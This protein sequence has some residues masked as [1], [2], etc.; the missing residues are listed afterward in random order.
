MMSTEPQWFV[1]QGDQQLGPYTGAQLV[2]FATQGNILRETPVWTEGME[3]WLPAEQI[4]GV[5][6]PAAAVEAAPG[7]ATQAAPGMATQPAPGMAPALDPSAPYPSP[8]TGNGLF[9]LWAGMFLGGIAMIIVGFLLVGVLARNSAVK[10]GTTGGMSITIEETVVGDGTPDETL[11]ELAAAEPDVS[12]GEVAGVL[13]A[14]LLGM[15]GYLLV[16]LSFIPFYMTLYRAW[17]CLVPGGLART[18]PGKAIGFMFIPFFNLYWLFQAVNGLATDWNRTVETYTDLKP[19]PRL[20]GGVFMTCCIGMFL[21]PLGLIMM[22][23]VM[24]QMSKGVNYFA[25]RPQQHEPGQVG[26]RL[27]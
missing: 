2:E 8:G 5:F 13:I 16:I 14:S 19:A 18:P 9:G 1:M 6:P 20:S 24:S 25:F 10:D 22:F 7:M 27:G 21:Q 4:E 3:N 23:P 11:G 17:K 15:A 26:F 12:G